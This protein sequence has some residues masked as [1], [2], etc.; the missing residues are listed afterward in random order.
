MAKNITKSPNDARAPGL[1]EFAKSLRPYG[2]SE[3]IPEKNNISKSVV[4]SHRAQGFDDYNPRC[5]F[6]RAS[7]RFQLVSCFHDLLCSLRLLSGAIFLARAVPTPPAVP[8][9]ALHSR[10]GIR[11]TA[12]MASPTLIA[13]KIQSR[14]AVACRALESGTLHRVNR[15]LHPLSPLLPPPPS[16]T[17]VSRLLQSFV[18]THILPTQCSRSGPT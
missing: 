11:W 5:V 10:V 9:M 6:S 13:M 12:H 7:R 4:P 15:S 18:S 1:A 16:P 2:R 17:P 8:P 14:A 3:L